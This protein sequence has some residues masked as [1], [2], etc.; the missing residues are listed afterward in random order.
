MNNTYVK[1]IV[2]G[3]LDTIAMA[4]TAILVYQVMDAYKAKKTDNAQV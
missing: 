4:C 1:A 2:G 3:L